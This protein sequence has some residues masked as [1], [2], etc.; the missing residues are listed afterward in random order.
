MRATHFQEP[1]AAPVA[2]TAAVDAHV[3]ALLLQV[4][5]SFILL[6]PR[7]R[8]VSLV[9]KRW[10]SA[11]LRSIEHVVMPTWRPA[12]V[13]ASI[14]N[15]LPCLTSV[16]VSASTPNAA[17]VLPMHVRRLKLSVRP[18][19]ASLLTMPPVTE[20]IFLDCTGGMPRASCTT[21]SLHQ[22]HFSLC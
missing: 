21:A 3:A 5:H 14:L 13:Q 11:A 22:R 1:V 10:R 4:I 9:C 20:L 18:H 19:D 16:A 2:I 6:R 12:E 17:I 7:L 15:L 8:S